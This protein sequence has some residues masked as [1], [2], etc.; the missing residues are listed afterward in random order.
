MAMI[1][2]ALTGCATPATQI[3]RDLSP[4]PLAADPGNVARGREI[5]TGRDGNC[6]LCHVIPA[7]G[8]TFMG[9]LGPTLAGV[10]ARLNEAQ[11][12]RQLIDPQRL[13]PD[14]IMPAYARTDG[15]TQVGKSWR[16]KPILATQQI[17]D[18]VAF[19]ATLR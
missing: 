10:G 4:M 1:A 11:L 8:A 13:N 9:N 18:T 7:T 5:V 14:S 2:A 16:D 3:V 15:F 17:E 6:V 19:L 12:R